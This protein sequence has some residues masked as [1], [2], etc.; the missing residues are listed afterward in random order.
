MGFRCDKCGHEWIQLDENHSPK[1]CPGCK[2][3]AWDSP[4]KLPNP[5]LAYEDFRD[6]V[7]NTLAQAGPLTWT[8]IR[9][10]A[11]LPQRLPNNQWVRRLESDIGLRRE[12]DIHGIIIWSLDKTS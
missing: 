1:V 6:S 5:L 2:S 4:R 10:A 11:R 9:T 12:K 8:E 7:R 3:P